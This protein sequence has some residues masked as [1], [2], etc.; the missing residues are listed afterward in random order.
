MEKSTGAGLTYLLNK[1]FKE[2]TPTAAAGLQ[3]MQKYL[4]TSRLARARKVTRFH[5]K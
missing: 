3:S 1:N 5:K 4:M 2:Q